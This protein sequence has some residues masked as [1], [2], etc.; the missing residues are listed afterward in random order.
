MGGSNLY[1]LEYKR[2]LLRANRAAQQKRQDRLEAIAAELTEAEAVQVLRLVCA[3][4]A[5]RGAG[6]SFRGPELPPIA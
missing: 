3:R 1:D 6:R 5:R 4:R 2:A